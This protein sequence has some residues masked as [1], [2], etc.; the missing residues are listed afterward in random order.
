MGRILNEQEDVDKEII[1]ILEG[2]EVCEN[3]RRFIEEQLAKFC[4][5]Q[6]FMKD[7][8]RTGAC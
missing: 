7:P 2:A 6:T 5:Q 3:S 4:L 8:E 1:E